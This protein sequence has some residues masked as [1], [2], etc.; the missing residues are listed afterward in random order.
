M[1]QFKQLFPCSNHKIFAPDW[2]KYNF[3]IPCRSSNTTNYY[4]VPKGQWA[5][6]ETLKNILP[7]TEIFQLTDETVIQHIQTKLYSVAKINL[8]FISQ[9]NWMQGANE[10]GY[11]LF[12]HFLQSI[13][14]QPN[15]QL[16]IVAVN[17]LANPAVKTITNP[18]DAVYLGLGKTLEK[19]LTQVNIQ[20]FNIA[21]VDKQTL[22]RI[23]NYP[24]IASPLSPIHIVE[25]SYY[26]TGLKTHN[27]PVSVKNKGFKTG[28]RY[29]IIGGNGGIG[30]VLA[31]YLLKH[32]QAELIL[33]GR[34][35]PS[36]AL[37]AR[38]QSK[39]IFFEQVDMTVQESVNALFAKHT[40]LDG[41]IHSALVLDDSSIA[42]MKPE[43]LLRVLAPKV[44][45]S[46]H[47]INAI[48][49]YNL[50]FVLF[51][52]SIQSFIANAGQANYTAACLCKDS[53]AGLLNDLFMINTKIINWGYWGSV[54][55]VANDFY[56]QRMEQQEIGSIEVDEGIE[57]I[58]QILQS[59]L[60]Q[61]AVVKGSEK[62]LLRMG[63]TLYSDPEMKESF[64]P[65][66]DRQDETIQVNKVSMMA[67]ENYSRH[68][69][70]QTAKPDSILP[71]YQRLW[72]AV[73]S[74]GYMPSPGK[75]QLLIQYP[76]IKAHLELIDICLNHFATIVSGTQD[77]LS[78]LFPEG[79]FH[80]VEA[81]Y[82]NNPVADYYNQQVANTVLNYIHQKRKHSNQT[83]RILE[84]GAG[85]GSTSKVV[86]PKLMGLNVCYVYTDLSH[87]FL[88]KARREFQAYDFIEYELFNVEKTYTSKSQFDLV[89]ATNVIHATKDIHNTINNIYRLLNQDGLFILNE[90][91]ERQD[92]ATLTF[93]LT[94][95][96]WLSNDALRI[97]YS[98]LLSL[99]SWERV[100]RECGFDT[101]DAHGDFGQH[102][103]AAHIKEKRLTYDHLH[104]GS[105]ACAITDK[106]SALQSNPAQ[107][108]L[109]A[110]DWL[111]YLIA[112]IMHIPV[113]EIEADIPF[114]DYGIDSLI[115]LELIQPMNA[116]VGYVPATVLF[117]YPTLN[118]LADYFTIQHAEHFV[119]SSSNKTSVTSPKA[120]EKQS[121]PLHSNEIIAELRQVIGH[122]MHIPIT[123]LDENTPFSDY[124]IDSLISLEILKP[125]HQL[126]GYLP[127]TILFEYPTIHSLA[128][129]LVSAHLSSNN[130]TSV[131]AEKNIPAQNNELDNAVA[132]IGIAGQFP[133]AD[134]CD[135]LWQLLSAGKHA[136]SLV[137]KE[138]WSID[139]AKKSYTQTGAF[140]RDIDAFDHE[141][142][143]I[144]P[145]EAERIDPQERLFLQTTYHAIQNAGYSLEGLQGKE[146]GC[147]VGVM[148]HGYTWLT[149]H[150]KTQGKPDSLF[151]SIANRVSYQF[152]WN[153]PSFAIDSA[154]SSS[155][156][157]LHTAVMAIQQSD[158]AIAVVG[159]V[160]LIVH[161]LQFDVLCQL[162]MLSHCNSCKPFAAGADGFVDGEGIISLVLTS[163]PAAVAEGR[164][165]YGI[166]RGTAVN[167]GGKA[168]GYSAPN[169][170]AQAAVIEK[171]LKRANLSPRDI[172][173]IEAHGTGTELG[174]PIEI[175][176]L[177]QVFHEA[178]Q[179]SIPIGSIKGNIG[180]LES[181]AGLAA[182]VKAL[183]QMQHQQLVPS[184]H[185]EKE[186][187]HLQL[188]NTPFYVNKSLVTWNT[189][190]PRRAAISSFGAG[191]ANAHVIIESPPENLVTK[192]HITTAKHYFFPLSAHSERALQNELIH[193][194]DIVAMQQQNLAALSYGYCCIRSS[195]NYRAGFI[196]EHIAELEDLL[197]LDLQQLYVLIKNRKS[198]IK[199]SDQ[200]I[201]HYLQS[202][203]QNKALA[204]DLMDA[205]N[206]G[207]AID[208]RRLLDQSV[209]TS[210]PN[211]AFTKHRHWV[212]AEESSFN[213][214][215]N[216]IKQHS[217]LKKSMAPAAL[218]FS[219]LVEQCKANVFTGVVWKNI[220]TDLDNL[221]IQTEHGRFSLSNKT[222][223]TVYSEGNWQLAKVLPI[224]E[225]ITSFTRQG[226]FIYSK[227]IYQQFRENGYDYGPHYQ[228]IKQA[229]ITTDAIYSVIEVE[230][231]WGFS[232]SPILIDAALQTA[233]LARAQQP[234]HTDEIKV[235]FF[236]DS[237]I[238]YRLPHNEPVY[239]IC[240]PKKINHS[241]NTDTVY[242]IE[243]S[244]VHRNVLMVLKGVV[245]IT[246]K[247]NKLFEPITLSE[248]NSTI[249]IF[250]LN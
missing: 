123:E 89:L 235:P 187:P 29:L 7:D 13:R 83:I 28:G 44:Q 141:F 84:V 169:P 60:Q 2:K 16:A 116:K 143:K 67:L 45:G 59:D 218:T 93:G 222:K 19:E 166:I 74:I 195:L 131:K 150:D 91:T 234:L 81:I 199:S 236:V 23:N 11:L 244:D 237:F 142:F 71:R 55:I 205:F 20:N 180:H 213:Q 228:A 49:Y 223:N 47:L 6:I 5:L 193:L 174:D 138:R 124:G 167:A 51:F 1:T 41:I 156:T 10:Q 54:G 226:Q 208:W 99:T 249:K 182:V 111:I 202:G 137:P 66:F 36:A 112:E 4:I 230:Q 220:I 70:Y 133:N 57:I 152:N 115:T 96:W 40:K 176:G 48:A 217:M 62:T 35:K 200:L 242:D 25:N 120:E 102:V 243:L 75:A 151:W 8:V 52:S 146:V 219:L 107:S 148:N 61:V 204:I 162:H 97:P 175:R 197:H 95:G 189:K 113:D 65:Y 165:I 31:D 183:L 68:Q 214:R 248:K 211:Y 164:R 203:S 198:K 154:C 50:D 155:L 163:Y 94:D 239:C 179:G 30:K 144:T 121:S 250:E 206:Q 104:S 114:S 100:L 118:Q 21:K 240:I 76:G 88:N 178:D 122:T 32:Y 3:E 127:A 157:A 196:V 46:I 119:N 14:L 153:G 27:L 134:S 77:A 78:I 221:T 161:P 12:L 247:I 72:E 80:L 140:I 58:E 224:P 53:I 117:E 33:V 192:S 188:S 246:T 129:Y 210:L 158:C 168:N 227:A 216:L 34:S 92:F 132:I 56:R 149:L 241:P 145:I 42:Q 160:N 130:N 39:T 126:F 43:Q 184:I 98:P 101:V 125:L 85:T 110:K 37:Q 79:S 172:H 170:K 82:R 215:A 26:S 194:K 18:L 103:I 109:L 106:K 225:K 38:Y 159:G 86:I 233:I 73:N 63:L 64:L 238:I 9:S 209:P 232:L 186:N 69:F 90:I 136:Y 177:S 22:E 128:D 185:C 212:H 17:A 24:F 229:C 135:E 105:N 147:Y 201:D 190:N 15:S 173:Y 207:E 231:D 245:S 139:K 181:A 191:G 87:A 108:N 171:A